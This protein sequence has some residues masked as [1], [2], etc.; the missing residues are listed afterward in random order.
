MKT[1]SRTKH[2]RQ[3][4]LW[5]HVLAAVAWCTMQLAQLALLLHGWAS[6]SPARLTTFEL[7]EFLENTILDPAAIIAAYTGMMLSALTS[8]GFFKHRW[9]MVK[10]VITVAALVIASTVVSRLLPAVIE[11]LRAGAEEPRIPILVGTCGMACAT[12]FMLWV[13]VVKPWGK[14]ARYAA[15]LKAKKAKGRKDPEPSLLIY[16]AV[17]LIPVVEFG[18]AF[19]YPILTFGSVIAY[20]VYRSVGR[21]HAA[22]SGPR[23]AA[24]NLPN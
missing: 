2:A 22:G 24:G 1:N 18:F 20:S 11:A 23:T 14:T 3:L 9:V 8:W 19:D 4:L 16:V 21:R 15:E 12:A 7:A 5:L 17:F 6:A 10:F 13:S